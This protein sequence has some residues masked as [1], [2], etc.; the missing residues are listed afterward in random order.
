MW[1]LMVAFHWLIFGTE[2]QLS[3]LPLAVE[4]TKFFEAEG[5]GGCHFGC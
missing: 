3:F 2:I 1:I 4:V 5:V